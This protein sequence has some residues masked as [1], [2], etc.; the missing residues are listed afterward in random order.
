LLGRKQMRLVYAA[1]H[2]DATTRNVR[3]RR[4]D[5]QRFCITDAEVLTLAD[6]AI[7]I[8]AHYSEKAGRPTPMDIEWAKDGEDGRLSS[9]RHD[10]RRSSRNASPDRSRPTP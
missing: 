1:G 6:D 4:S 10:P 3:T 2:G 8:E 5:R 9:S 7:R